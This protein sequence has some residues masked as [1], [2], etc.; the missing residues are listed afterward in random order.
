MYVVTKQGKRLPVDDSSIDYDNDFVPFQQ[1]VGLY[2][3]SAM[4]NPV[5]IVSGLRNNSYHIHG[6]KEELEFVAEKIYEHRPSFEEVLW[7]MS[8]NGLSRYDIVEVSEGYMLD[9]EDD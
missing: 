4:L 9:M 6:A 2:D 5:W 8:A 3:D 1:T 7:F